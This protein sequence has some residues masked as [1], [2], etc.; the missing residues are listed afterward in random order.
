MQTINESVGNWSQHVRFWS[1]MRTSSSRA[2]PAFTLIGTNIGGSTSFYLNLCKHLDIFLARVK[3]VNYFD[4]RYHKGEGGYRSNFLLRTRLHDRE[5]VRRITVQRSVQYL[6][7]LPTAHQAHQMMPDLKILFL[8][9]NTA[10]RAYAHY[11]KHIRQHH[12]LISKR[13]S[14]AVYRFSGQQSH[15]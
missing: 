15:E 2:L 14:V 10:R 1:H 13:D 7:Y 8:L 6:Y 12:K 4:L 11:H 3:E 9:R 5:G